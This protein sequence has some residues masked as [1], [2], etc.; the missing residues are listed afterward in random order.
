MEK[1][2]RQESSLAAVEVRAGRSAM[3]VSKRPITS[4]LEAKRREAQIYF[5]FAGSLFAFCCLVFPWLYQ[6]NRT[7]PKS[8]RF[9]LPYRL[10]GLLYRRLLPKSP[11]TAKSSDMC[12]PRAYTL[13]FGRSSDRC[14]R[15]SLQE[16]VSI[17]SALIHGYLEGGSRP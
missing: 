7:R 4:R 12:G 17:L 5:Y 15:K 10:L 16:T 8:F 6:R 9:P 14:C 11:R 13:R 3:N 2:Q 1:S